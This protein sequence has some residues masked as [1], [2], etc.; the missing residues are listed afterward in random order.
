MRTVFNELST[1]WALSR[2]LQLLWFMGYFWNFGYF[3]WQYAIERETGGLRKITAFGVS[4]TRGAAAAQM[5]AYG[6]LLI[7]MYESSCIPGESMA[8]E[9]PL[10]DRRPHGL[11]QVP[12]HF[13]STESYSSKAHLPFR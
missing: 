3:F 2:Q 1:N 13:R 12:Q 6:T 5:W 9:L 11:L 10:N 4:T 8:L 7:P